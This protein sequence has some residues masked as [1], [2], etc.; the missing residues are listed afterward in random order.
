MKRFAYLDIEANHTNWYDA[1]IIEVAF[2]IKDED[3]KDLDYFQSLI[4][5]K[6]EINPEITQLTGITQQML[7]NA[8]VLHIVA[9][10]IHDKL[11]GCI[12]VAHKIKTPLLTSL[13]SIDR[14]KLH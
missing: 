12:I 8:P 6:A 2:I 1:Q 9:Q 11:E 4:K 5:P 13:T 10:K 14:K 3:G 7:N